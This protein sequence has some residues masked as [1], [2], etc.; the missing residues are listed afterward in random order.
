MHRV[1]SKSIP[2]PPYMERQHSLGF[3]ERLK[4]FNHCP[5]WVTVIWPLSAY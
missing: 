3:A 1:I 5:I 2:G 4:L